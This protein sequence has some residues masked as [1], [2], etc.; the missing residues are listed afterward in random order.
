M[1]ERISSA[2]AAER[3]DGTFDSLRNRTRST[4]LAHRTRRGKQHPQVLKTEGANTPLT[5]ALSP[6]EHL[7]IK[8]GRVST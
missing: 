7:L 6:D 2:L 1:S 4:F 8:R 3:R 5:S